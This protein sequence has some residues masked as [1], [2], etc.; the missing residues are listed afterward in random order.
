MCIQ[1][2]G[3]RLVHPGLG[4][5]LETHPILVSILPLLEGAYKEYRIP[6][7]FLSEGIEY[8]RHGLMLQPTNDVV[9]V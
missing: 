1:A 4:I 2:P 7:L 6:S 8:A 3:Y 5:I 9:V